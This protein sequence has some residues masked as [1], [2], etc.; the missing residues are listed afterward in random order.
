MKISVA[1]F[2]REFGAPNANM[3]AAFYELPLMAAHGEKEDAGE[4]L[5]A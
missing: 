5:F 2:R 1:A 3:T 4:S